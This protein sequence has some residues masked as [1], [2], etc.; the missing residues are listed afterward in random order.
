MKTAYFAMA[1]WLGVALADGQD[2]NT[3]GAT[4]SP[5]RMVEPGIFE[6]GKVR[7]DQARRCVTVPAVL[8]RDQGPMEYFLVSS[9]GKTHES[10]L[11]TEAEPYDIHLA[12]LLLGAQPRASGNF[13]GSPTNGIP[14][15]IINPSSEIIPGDKVAISVRWQEGG[16]EIHRAAED[17]VFNTNSQS[18]LAHGFW[19]Y[20]GSMIVRNA[21]LAQ[22]DGS[23]ASLVTDPVALINNT[24]EGHDNDT[25][26]IPNTT[27]LP[28]PKVPVEVTITL[29]T[30]KP[31]K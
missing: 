28:P 22:P 14:G 5:V 15:P 17:L 11:R 31:P 7:L 18:V 26:W 25:I 21:F 23:I 1:F 8:N 2:T 6:V 29:E 19:V 12:M 9:Y 30:A 27:N 4:N 10:V 20:N 16:A 13:P 24:A 3:A